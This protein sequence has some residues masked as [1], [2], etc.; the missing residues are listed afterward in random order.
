MKMSAAVTLMLFLGAL[1]GHTDERVERY[2]ISDNIILL[3]RGVSKADATV[4]AEKYLHERRTASILRVTIGSDRQELLDNKGTGFPD[5][6][7]LCMDIHRPSH[8]MARLLS[9]NG[10]ALMSYQPSKNTIEP[11][12]QWL[13]AGTADP[14]LFKIGNTAY[15]LL[16]FWISGLPGTNFGTV[17][18]TF[19]FQALSRPSVNEA[20]QLLS[21]MKKLTT[22]ERVGISIRTDAFFLD[23]TDFPRFFPFYPGPV[24]GFYDW[25]LVKPG[26][27]YY[28]SPDVTCHIDGSK[29]AECVQFDARP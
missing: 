15:R 10:G 27:D 29:P 21:T 23:D 4:I 16:H 9:L 13:I 7:G 1:S 22:A 17:N 26:V 12:E 3:A 24:A 8:P 19:Y 5:S 28:R 18:V 2:G 6:G 11:A 20:K 14:S 25:P